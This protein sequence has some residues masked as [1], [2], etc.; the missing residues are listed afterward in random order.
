MKLRSVYLHEGG[1]QLLYELLKERDEITNI[2]HRQLP[3][4]PSHVAFVASKPYTAWY[5]IQ[6]DKLETYGAIYLSKTDEI[7]VFIFRRYRGNGYGPSAVRKLMEM[8]PRDR[9]LANINPQNE[10]S[11]SMFSG[12]GFRHIQNT[13]ELRPQS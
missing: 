1:D 5:F 13:L 2:S 11:I 6:G 8:H 10:R 9:Y 7:G 3:D 4:W 12:M